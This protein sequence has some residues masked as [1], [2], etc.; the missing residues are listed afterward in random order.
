MFAFSEGQDRCE[1]A[2]T[3]DAKNGILGLDEIKTYQDGRYLCAPEACS[4]LFEFETNRKSHRVQ[5]LPFHL[6]DQQNTV[7]EEDFVQR[8][9]DQGARKTELLAFL[10][11]MA[12]WT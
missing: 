3:E 7:F 6:N 5:R 11:S 12:V 2:L 10:T 9:V 1:A 4:T 8:A